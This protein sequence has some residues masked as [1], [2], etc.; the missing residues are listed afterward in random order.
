MCHPNLI[1]SFLVRSWCWK[2]EFFSSKSAVCYLTPSW[3]GR[4]EETSRNTTPNFKNVK[5]VVLYAHTAPTLRSVLS[6]PICG[7]ETTCWRRQKARFE[8]FLQPDAGGIDSNFFSAIH[9]AKSIFPANGN[10]CR[11]NIL[12]LDWFDC[13]MPVAWRDHAS[14]YRNKLFFTIIFG[15]DIYEGKSVWNCSTF[16]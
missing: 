11:A 2:Q 3:R 4:E 7:P 9:Y 15:N 14:Y 13:R 5:F 10:V 6:P 8:R 12:Y 1:P 16:F